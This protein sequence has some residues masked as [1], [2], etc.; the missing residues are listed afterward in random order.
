MNSKKTNRSGDKLTKRMNFRLT[1]RDI[2]ILEAL[3]QKRYVATYQIMEMFWNES[4][5]GEHGRKKACERRMR[6]LFQAGLVRRIEQPTKRGNGTKPFIYA[7]SND[8]ATALISELGID[9]TEIEWQ[10]KSREDNYPFMDHLLLTTDIHIA[11]QKACYPIGFE[12][13]TWYDEKELRISGM[14]DRVKLIGPEGQEKSTAVIPDAVFIL[15]REGKQGLFFVEIDR[16][17][18]TVQ[19]SLWERKG[20]SKKVAAYSEYLGSN[21]YRNRYGER[22]ARILTITTGE[23]RLNHLKQATEIAKGNSSFWFTTFE[24]ALNP[25]KLLTEPIWWVAGRNELRKLVQ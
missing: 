5:G 10:P 14:T 2:Q 21:E 17:T 13:S 15:E 25:L 16:R 19:P 1:L 18:V 24:L 4:H 23:K 11:L 3:H 7:L 9:P 12:L 20:W 6:M 22:N 8:G